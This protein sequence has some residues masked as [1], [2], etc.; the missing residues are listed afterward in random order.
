M[1]S[2]V[3]MPDL[4]DPTPKVSVWFVKPGERVDAGDR[5]VEILIGGATIDLPAPTTGRLAVRVAQADDCVAT[6]QVLGYI[7]EED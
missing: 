4:G 5:L 3:L 1:R 2:P 6:G 7:E